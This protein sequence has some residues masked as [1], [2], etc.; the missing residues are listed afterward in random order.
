M[1]FGFTFEPKNAIRSWKKSPNSTLYFRYY[2]FYSNT[3]I[4]YTTLKLVV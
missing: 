4:L 1:A 2:Y 3:E